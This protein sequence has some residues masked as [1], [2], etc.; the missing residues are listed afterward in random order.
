MK[1][2]INTD[3]GSRSNPGPSAIGVVLSDK[4]GNVLKEVSETIGIATNNQAEYSA[5]VRGLQEAKKLKAD[6]VDIMMDSELVVKQIKQEYKVK[7]KDLAIL[8]VKAWN[9]LQTF[10]KWS[11]KHVR[12]EKNER[13]DEL[14][15]KA[16]DNK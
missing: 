15:N 1:V 8:F 6:E 5:L 16:L 2:I 12:R 14:V 7:D 9:I 13:A 3:G 10:E 11:I 4:N